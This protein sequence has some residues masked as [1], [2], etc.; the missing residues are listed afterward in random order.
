MKISHVL[1]KAAKRVANGS[2]TLSCCAIWGSGGSVYPDASGAYEFY[3]ALFRPLNSFS[4]FWASD[5]ADGWADEHEPEGKH[6][7]IVALCLA[8]AIAKA[9]GK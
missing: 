6:T 9:E 4:S 2:N 7:R 1:L 8:A 3:I 5:E